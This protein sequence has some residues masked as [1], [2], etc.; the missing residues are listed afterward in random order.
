M[1]EF[2]R[3]TETKFFYTRLEQSDTKIDDAITSENNRQRDCVEMIAPKNYLSRAVRDGVASIMSMT[4][5]E[6]YPGKR[7]HAGVDNIDVIE[8]LA[9]ERA[10][11]MFGAAHANVQPN[12]GTQ[13]RF[14]KS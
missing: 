14:R 13:S 7:Y 12:S 2:V 1:D 9:I 4:S 11:Q 5:I 8:R 3:T 10:N 6:G